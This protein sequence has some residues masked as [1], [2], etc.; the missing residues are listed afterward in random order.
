MYLLHTIEPVLKDCLVFNFSTFGAVFFSS[1]SQFLRNKSPNFHDFLRLLFEKVFYS[2]ESSNTDF[3]VCSMYI[4]TL[5][6]QFAL[7]SYKT[8]TNCSSPTT[9]LIQSFLSFFNVPI[10]FMQRNAF[11]KI[12]IHETRNFFKVGTWSKRW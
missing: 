2:N 5:G 10:S 8:T 9:T 3:T 4:S 6:Y 11:F 12:E 1:F 7:H